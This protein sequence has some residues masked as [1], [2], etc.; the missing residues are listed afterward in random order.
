MKEWTESIMSEWRFLNPDVSKEHNLGVR[1]PRSSKDPKML[2]LSKNETYGK[3]QIS[4]LCGYFMDFVRPVIGAR[5][6]AA[7][8]TTSN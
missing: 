2:L 7:A 4:L 1:H 3:K 6:R 8:T 5:S